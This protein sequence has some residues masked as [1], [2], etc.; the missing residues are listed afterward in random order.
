MRW[1]DQRNYVG[2]DRRGKRSRRLLDRRKHD[3]TSHAPALAT[4]LRQ[5][6]VRVLDAD[7]DE[8]MRDFIARTRA[9]AQLAEHRGE[10]RAAGGLHALV[11]ALEKS[12]GGGDLRP[13]IYAALD[14]IADVL[15]E[16]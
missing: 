2:P 15:I 6:R 9:L 4:A 1:V 7:R 8:G 16:S 11:R 10:A 13:Q 3:E 14:R 5:L 12:P